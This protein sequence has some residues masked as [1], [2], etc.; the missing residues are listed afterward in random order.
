MH[1][2]IFDTNKNID[3]SLDLGN[4][5]EWKLEVPNEVVAVFGNTVEIIFKKKLLKFFLYFH[6]ILMC[7]Y[8]K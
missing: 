7:W 1:E 5:T 6:I 8:K 4:K 2:E 3:L